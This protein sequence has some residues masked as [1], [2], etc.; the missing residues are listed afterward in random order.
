MIF[1]FNTLVPWSPLI[2]VVLVIIFRLVV[3]PPIRF[4]AELGVLSL[5]DE[6]VSRLFIA[7]YA[8]G[9]VVLLL[10]PVPIFER[11]SL[12]IQHRC[13]GLF[14]HT[15][16]TGTKSKQHAI[17]SHSN[18]FPLYIISGQRLIALLAGNPDWIRKNQ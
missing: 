3:Q 13:C 2:Y 1:H 11:V 18:I 6:R 17:S 15:G 4:L 8:L 10:A 14:I 5:W 12:L 16:R 9:G 7:G